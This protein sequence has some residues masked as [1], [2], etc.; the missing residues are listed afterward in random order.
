MTSTKR[1]ISTIISAL[2]LSSCAQVIFA[3]NS[4]TDFGQLS[5][6]LEPGKSSDLSSEVPGIIR[7]L[8]VQRGDTVKKGQVLMVLNSD[9]EQ[10][11][12]KTARARLDFAERKLQRNEALYKDKLI[13][14]HEQDELLTEK[15]LAR[16]QAEEALV[17]LRQREVR[18]PFSGV[19][20]D[21]V[22]EPGEYIDDSHFLQV[23]SLDPLHAQVIFQ[24]D[25]YGHIKKDTPITLFTK[26][27]E[28]GFTA[29]IKTLDPIIDAAS[30]TFGITVEVNNEQQQ[31]VA[32][33]RCRIEISAIPSGIQ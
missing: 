20:T 6:L 24:A 17:R 23:V 10:A 9:I 25:L 26:G 1:Q 5:C 27:S 21:V 33:S 28:Q 22:K 12:L 18:S 15:R 8:K 30:D 19:I 11:T 32:G 13:S 3:Q 4:T 2:L 16:L 29:R 14:D 7:D 31:L